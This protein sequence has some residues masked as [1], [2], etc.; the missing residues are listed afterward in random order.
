M[1]P[2]CDAPD[3][4]PGGG[5]KAYP[6]GFGY[7]DGRGM[8]PVGGSRD[9]ER[10]GNFMVRCLIHERRYGAPACALAIV[11]C[12]ALAHDEARGQDLEPRM[13]RVRSFMESGRMDRADREIGHILTDEPRN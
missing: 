3:A 10:R 5:C 9:V 11:A 1:H 4:A 7:S 8:V 12:L 2:I 6:G 13:K